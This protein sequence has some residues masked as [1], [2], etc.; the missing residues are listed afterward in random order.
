MPAIRA[1]ATSGTR[2]PKHLEH[3]LCRWWVLCSC[4]GMS[5]GRAK[6]WDPDPGR[7]PWPVRWWNQGAV[8]TNECAV[9]SLPLSLLTTWT[10]LFFPAPGL[11]FMFRLKAGHNLPMVFFAPVIPRL[12]GALDGLGL[13]GWAVFYFPYLVFSREY[14]WEKFREAEKTLIGRFNS[15]WQGSCT[16]ELLLGEYFSSPANVG[17]KA[18]AHM[19]LKC[20]LLRAMGIS[21]DTAGKVCLIRSLFHDLLYKSASK[22]GCQVPSWYW[23]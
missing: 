10:W 8:P 14:V 15:S 16:R 13:V 1:G 20:E 9:F 17:V 21:H 4:V 7:H 18:R 6:W 5:G 23:F 19:R 3:E 2:C 12:V 11:P 22:R